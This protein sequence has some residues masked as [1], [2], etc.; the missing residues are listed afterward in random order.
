MTVTEFFVNNPCKEL[1]D[2]VE[3]S[4]RTLL[5]GDSELS[6]VELNLSSAV[7]EFNSTF[8]QF[9]HGVG[10]EVFGLLQGIAL[11]V[12]H[13]NFKVRLQRVVSTPKHLL[14]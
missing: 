14:H 4:L 3:S 1:N 5:S 10:F 7:G 11:F 2:C 6:S 9:G 12:L 8:V 13:T